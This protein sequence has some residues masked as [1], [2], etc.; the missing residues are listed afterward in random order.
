[1]LRA[2]FPSVMFGPC[3]GPHGSG[4]RVRPS[5]KQSSEQ[6]PGSA[7]SLSFQCF[8]FPFPFHFLPLLFLQ[9]KASTRAERPGSRTEARAAMV[10][11]RWASL[12]AAAGL[13]PP[14][15]GSC[16][17]AGNNALISPFCLPAAVREQAAGLP[18]AAPADAA[19]PAAAPLKPAA[20]GAGEPPA[21]TGHR[22]PADPAPR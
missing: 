18:A 7:H 1:M 19:A 2:P 16:R 21:R 4:L 20:P 8:I 14:L 15:R 11:P 12:A 22:A 3:L 17:K 9:L 5:H 10:P 13:L 6:A